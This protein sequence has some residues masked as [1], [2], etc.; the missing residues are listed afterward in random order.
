MSLWPGLT[1][2]RHEADDEFDDLDKT[3]DFSST[4]SAASMTLGVI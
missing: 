4:R 3:D 1:R 2:K